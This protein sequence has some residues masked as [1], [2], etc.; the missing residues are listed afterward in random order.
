MK[1]DLE[2]AVLLLK[3]KDNITIL[4]HASPDGDTVGGGFALMLALRKLGK[5]VNIVNNDE[6]PEN[7]SYITSL[8]EKMN[9]CE[10]FVVSVDVADEKLLGE[11][12]LEQYGKKIDLAIDHHATNTLFAK[13]TYVEENSAS[14]CE[15]IYSVLLKLGVEISK[16]IANCL[17]T[18]LSTDT[19]CFRYSNVTPR[20]HEIAARLIEKGAE[21]SFINTKMFETKKL[22][23]FKLQTKCLENMKI[24]HDGKV[25]IFTVTQKML[26]ECGCKDSQVDAIVALSRQIEGVKI[27]V[28]IKEKEN[29]LFKV[30]IR[31][32]E[33]VDAAEICGLFSGGGHKRAAG[34]SF[35]C[36]LEETQKQ[37]EK[38][39]EKFIV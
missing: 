24:L 28:T 23:Y 5:S 1:I 27:G 11:K 26:S 2:R 10:Q 8:Y 33:D 37:L 19:G 22:G 6:Y 34:C 25:C 4:T 13:E 9:F 36:S 20:T 7:L 32:D 38:A 14:A 15:I 31:T 21:H 39:T 12:V 16:E 30:S 18:G 29:G 17:Y 35:S 3:E